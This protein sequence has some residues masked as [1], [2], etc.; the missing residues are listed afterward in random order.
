MGRITPDELAGFP[1]TRRTPAMAIEGKA[2]GATGKT[3]PTDVEQ[4]EEAPKATTVCS[5]AEAVRAKV[6]EG[7]PDLDN[8]P[9]RH[10]DEKTGALEIYASSDALMK[11]VP[12]FDWGLV[13][14][15]RRVRLLDGVLPRKGLGV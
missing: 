2:L 14:V 8:K 9:M 10:V 13:C 7:G 6:A 5:A 15:R 3:S 11:W 1:E 12:N 4:E